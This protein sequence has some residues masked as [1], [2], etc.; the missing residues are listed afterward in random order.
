LEVPKHQVKIKYAKQ[1]KLFGKHLRKIRLQKSLT[2]EE[3]AYRAGISFN[4]LNT[5]ENASLNPTLATLSAIAHGLQI[6]LKELID[7]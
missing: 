2:Q 6:D 7:F 3:L 4:S 1:L 5:I